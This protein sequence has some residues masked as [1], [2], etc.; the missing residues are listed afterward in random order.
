MTTCAFKIRSF[1]VTVN[2]SVR[3]LDINSEQTASLMHD[4]YLYAGYI[5]NGKSSDWILSQIVFLSLQ[6]T[7]L[8]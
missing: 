8:E 3:T 2:I 5:I 7:A 1:I 4:C 6:P